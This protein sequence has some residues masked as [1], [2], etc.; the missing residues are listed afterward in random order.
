MSK[1]IAAVLAIVAGLVAAQMAFARISKN[2]IHPVAVVTENGRHVVVTGPLACT[3]GERAYLSVT[4]TQRTT[5]AIA[6][7]RAFV[8]CT[9]D[10]EAWG[11]DAAVQGKER[12]EVGPALAVA[13]AWTVKRGDTTDAHQWL[14][15]ITLI[16][17]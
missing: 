9:G 13:I 2:T 12:F 15:P 17:E 3:L 6:E 7:G 5:G 4:I 16:A 8:I 10:E 11:V 1:R 14:V